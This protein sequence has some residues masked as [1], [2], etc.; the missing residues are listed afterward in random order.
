MSDGQRIG[1]VEGLFSGSSLVRIGAK[2]GCL[3]MFWVWYTFGVGEDVRTRRSAAWLVGCL[4]MSRVW[5]SF[6]VG[7]EVNICILEGLP[8]LVIC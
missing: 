3:W 6:P 7:E 8:W 5:Y 4:S 1:A 2:V